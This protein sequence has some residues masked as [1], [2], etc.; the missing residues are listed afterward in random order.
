MEV[1]FGL[2]ASAATEVSA[3]YWHPLPVSASS[4]T[5]IEMNCLAILWQGRCVAV[6]VVV[7][8][9]VKLVMR[10]D[11][12]C[13]GEKNQMTILERGRHIYGYDGRASLTGKLPTSVYR[14]DDGVFLS[15]YLHICVNRLVGAVVVLCVYV[16][17]L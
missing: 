10:W 11:S 14:T 3:T 7:V 16:T 5:L 6:A 1:P 15:G 12:E 2:V 13:C 4:P 9:G 8:L 17:F